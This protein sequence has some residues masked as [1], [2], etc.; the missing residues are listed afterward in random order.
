MTGPFAF[1]PDPPDENAPDQPLELITDRLRSLI[2]GHQQVNGG[3]WV[4]LAIYLGVD[5]WNTFQEQAYTD[6]H[7]QIH[8]GVLRWKYTKDKNI[9]IRLLADAQKYVRVVGE[10]GK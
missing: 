7:E 9:L 6:E 5:E 2:A 8:D 1:L 3:N 10:R 4:P